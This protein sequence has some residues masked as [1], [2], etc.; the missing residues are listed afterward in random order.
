[1]SLSENKTVYLHRQVQYPHLSCLELQRRKQEM[2]N[3]GSIR[4][5][6]T[7]QYSAAVIKKSSQVPPIPPPPPPPRQIGNC[8]TRSQGKASPE[9]VTSSAATGDLFTYMDVMQSVQH[10]LCKQAMK[11]ESTLILHNH[12]FSNL[13]NWEAWQPRIQPIGSE[14]VYK[15]KYNSEGSIWNKVLLAILA[16]AQMYFSVTYTSIGKPTA[17]GYLITR[18]GIDRWNITHLDVVLA[19]LNPTIDNDDINVS[20]P[21]GSPEGVSTPKI[22]YRLSKALRPY[23]KSMATAHWER[24]LLI[25]L[26]PNTVLDGSQHL[27]LCE[28]YLDTSVCQQYL[29]PISAGYLQW[30]YQGQG[31]TLREIQYHEPQSHMSIHW[32]R[33]LPSLHCS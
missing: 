23:R 6:L 21:E 17:F 33:D 26:L 1:M 25:L 10:N 20:L 24:Y 27:P 19:V 3:A 5:D 16:Y 13:L 8:I 22:I 12:I 18:I 4:Q 32:H 11:E 9:G 29:H 7:A 28:Q 14:W 2:P 30:C 31:D 15:T